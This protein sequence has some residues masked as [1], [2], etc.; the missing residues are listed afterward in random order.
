[1]V[2]LSFSPDFF[3]G[4]RWILV[5][6][7]T[8]MSPGR[9]ALATCASLLAAGLFIDSQSLVDDGVSLDLAMVEA[10]RL[11]QHTSRQCWTLATAVRFGECRKP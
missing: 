7:S 9:R 4:M 10:R 2:D 6:D 1:V 5:Q 3:G 8:G 11:F